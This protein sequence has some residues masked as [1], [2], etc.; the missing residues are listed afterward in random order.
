VEIEAKESYDV[1]T[2]QQLAEIRRLF[3]TE[4]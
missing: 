3:R 4:A 2:V 1:N